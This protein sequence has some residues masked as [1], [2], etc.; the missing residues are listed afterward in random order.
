[1]KLEGRSYIQPSTISAIHLVCRPWTFETVGYIPR[2]TISNTVL[3]FRFMKSG[4]SNALPN[5][6]LK[7][8]APAVTALAE[9]CG[10]LAFHF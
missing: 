7:L 2:C 9:S 4:E 8:A 10:M 1:M 6:R 5:T 3:A